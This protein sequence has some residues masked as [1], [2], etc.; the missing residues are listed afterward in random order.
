MKTLIALLVFGSISSSALEI[1][2][3]YTSN[4]MWEPEGNA[5]MVSEGLNKALKP[6]GCVSTQMGTKITKS[7]KQPFFGKD[8]PGKIELTYR[9]LCN[10]SRIAGFQFSASL[11]WYDEDYG[12][13]FY[14]IKLGGEVLEGSFCWYFSGDG[15]LLNCKNIFKDTQPKA[16]SKSVD[17]KL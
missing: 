2:Q 4:F 13:V 1:N 8:E 5:A 16:W 3:Q 15:S 7:T 6:Y 11:P 17:Q 14:R 10:D 9:T 12:R